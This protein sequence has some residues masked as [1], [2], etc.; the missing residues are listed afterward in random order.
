MRT[1]NYLKS[2][3]VCLFALLLIG[4]STSSNAQTVTVGT[5][6]GINGTFDYPCPIQDFYYATRVQ[7]L[8]TSAEL[9]AVGITGGATITEIGWIV[10]AT[11]ITGHLQ[12]DYTIAL[13]NTTVT[14][15]DLNHWETGSSTVY[16]PTDYAYPDGYAGNVMF[17]T[18]PFNYAGGNL[19]VEI[20]GGLP[21][22]GYTLNPACEQTTGLAFNGSHQ[23]RQDVATGCGSLDT[24]NWGTETTRPVMVVTYIS[25]APCSG[26]PT[27]GNTNSTANPVCA[28]TNFSLSM[29]N[30]TLGS[31]VTYQWQ[32]SPDGTTWTDIAGSTNFTA[33]LAQGTDTYYQCVVTCS[34]GGVGTSTPILVTTGQCYYMCSQGTNVTLTDSTNAFFDSGGPNGN[35]QLGESCT[36]TVAPSCAVTITLNFTA[37]N[38]GFGGYL[39]VYDGQT[40]ADPLLLT[41]SGSI[42]P[43][44]V[45][46]T[47]G[48]MLII[49]SSDAFNNAS[50]GWAAT[51]T[52]VIASS[53]AP[54]A[55]F[56]LST[57]TPP[58][59]AGVHF[60]DQSG[61]GVPTSW[62]WDFGDGNTSNI[63][64]PTHP[65][66][67]PGT[68]YITLY[69][70]SCTESDTAY[71]S[72]VVQNAPQVIVYPDTLSATVQCGDSAVFSLIVKNLTG[73]QLVF[74]TDGSAN[75]SV[76]M[77][78]MKYGTDLFS[79][80]PSTLAAINAYFT[81]YTLTETST[82]NPGTLA[83]LLVGKNVLLIPEQETA[84]PSV[85]NAFTPVFNMFLLNGGTIIQC[86]TSD[87]QDS[88]LTTTGLW[89]GDYV[90]DIGNNFT[91]FTVDSMSHPIMAG[92]SG[93]SL[94]APSATDVIHFTDSDRHVL[95]KYTSGDVV[96]YRKVNNGKVIYLGFDYFSAN[97]D[98]K[99]MIANAVE[100]GG[101][102]GLPSWI[103]MDITTDT[104]SSGDSSIVTVVFHANGIPA[105]T[106][107]GI[108]GVTT[109]DPNTPYV[110][111]NCTMTV[112]GDPIIAMSE[113]CLTFDT[114]LAGNSTTETFSIINDG[115]DS[116]I[117]ANY[118]PS[119]PEFTVSAPGSILFPGTSMVVTVTFHPLTAGAYSGTLLIQNNDND[120]TICLNGFAIPAP[121]ID[122][123]FS[124]VSQFVPAC[125]ATDSTTFTIHNTG[126]SNLIFTI[127]GVPVW[128]TL[129]TNSGTIA[130]GDSLVVTVVY[131]S[132]T[133]AGGLVNANLTISSND[134]QGP[135]KQVPL[136]M[137]V[138]TNPCFTASGIIDA[139]T[140]IATF[141]ST[142]I[143]NPVTTW[144]WDFGDG[145][146]NTVDANPIH[147]YGE[148]TGTIINVI[149]IGCTAGGCDTEYVSLTMPLV[150][151]PEA[152]ACLP[153]T[154]NPGTGG[155]LGI[156]ITNFTFGH[157]SNTSTGSASGYQNFTCSDTTTL[158]PGDHYMWSII[159]G[160]TYEETVKG[161]IDF[162]NDGAFDEVTELVF[163]D[164]A[165]VYNHGGLSIQIPMTAVM[166]VALRMRIESEYSGNTEPNGCI[167]LLYGQNEDY[168]VFIDTAYIVEHI[169]A[170]STPVAMSVYP[171]PFSKDATIE[172]SIVSSQKVS[173]EV[174]NLVGE[175]VQQFA[176]DEIQ[177]AGKH[178]YIFTQETPGVYFVK[179]SVGDESKIVKLVHVR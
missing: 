179:L 178:T 8:Y 130:A 166:G 37:F 10:Q 9:A 160:Q 114:V 119:S 156:G 113:T 26:T 162:N 82:S 68:Y 155:S 163:E 4:S 123:I 36:L 11:A 121:V 2:W 59:N 29:Q 167:D 124:T 34:G 71:D 17:T 148:P 175:R 38:G 44:P 81:N 84:T 122:S 147:Q 93:N 41:A 23:W 80:Y 40:T 105:G 92:I 53:T 73:G 78:S 120:T 27:P 157:I 136:T 94:L 100:W 21:S 98:T 57:H 96:S 91:N 159:T 125:S 48:Y 25:A 87:G 103:T 171:N 132:G 49:W 152:A 89:H 42:V 135:N 154:T 70:F 72:V 141:T 66:A 97:D 150:T 64:N 39:Y 109:N 3:S 50:S 176:G 128:A 129:S 99:K 19:I 33:T 88:T 14:T 140:G 79:E 83:N 137:D 43:A 149:V 127:T 54:I 60:T 16:G 85:F 117:I 74:N 5:T 177:P 107:Y 52:S 165:I 101:Q 161:Y 172:Y 56:G 32:S 20:C 35:Y 169:N 95:A 63:Q 6:S 75:S 12:E 110:A 7:F 112:V 28:N 47:S 24:T 18:T 133:I 139:C 1:K 145:G 55:S 174:F 13:I 151:G 90:E 76:K 146:T 22:G 104:V 111:V 31:G 164:S 58:L 77:V 170:F 46:C 143:V 173:V 115:C 131:S 168:T 45:T 144:S 86:G 153:Q 62:I 134:P 102:S 142:T 118:V 15:L 61:G 116:L 69:A 158:N 138:G 51:W 65:Y 126:G 108:I 67:A 106:Y 30:Y